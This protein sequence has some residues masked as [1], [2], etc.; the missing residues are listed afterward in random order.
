MLLRANACGYEIRNGEEENIESIMM[1][2]G[3]R[4][5]NYLRA[6]YK[7]Y[8]LNGARRPRSKNHHRDDGENEKNARKKRERG[9]ERYY[10]TFI[11]S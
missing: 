10:R 7:R 6:P 1:R 4:E 2:E 11:I 5:E 9:A 3:S 8:R